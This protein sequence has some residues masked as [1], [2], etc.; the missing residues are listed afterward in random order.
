MNALVHLIAPLVLSA[1]AT[2]VLAW[3]GQARDTAGS[4]PGRDEAV[5]LSAPGFWYLDT[6]ST[7][8]WTFFALRFLGV[9]MLLFA[10]FA[11]LSYGI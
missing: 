6:A 10:L 3:L 5:P 2:L 9:W 1:T 4:T 7:A 11:A 8:S